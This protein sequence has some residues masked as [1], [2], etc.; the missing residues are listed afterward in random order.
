MLVRLFVASCLRLTNLSRYRNW[1][2]MWQN[3][4]WKLL[5][6]LICLFSP[7]FQIDEFIWLKELFNCGS[8]W[9]NRSAFSSHF[10]KWQIYLSSVFLQ[11][12]WNNLLQKL[13][14]AKSIVGIV[15][16]AY[17]FT[18]TLFFFFQLPNSFHRGNWD[19][20]IDTNNLF[21]VDLFNIQKK[22]LNE[23]NDAYIW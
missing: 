13:L 22:Q 20:T 15:E 2:N 9:N 7:F 10:I 5:K 23:T 19:T 11:R 4:L 18:Y 14:L 21:F 12:N 17:F 16:I 3:Q 1:N 8:C 6:S